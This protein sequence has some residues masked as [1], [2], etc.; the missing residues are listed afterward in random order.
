MFYH[1]TRFE[2]R[3]LCIHAFTD[4]L[5]KRNTVVHASL[6]LEGSNLV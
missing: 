1:T 5:Q 3:F 2:Q 4:S 6:C